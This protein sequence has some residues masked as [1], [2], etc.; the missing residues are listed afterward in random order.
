M[1]EISSTVD[2]MPVVPLQRG[3]QHRVCSCGA[4]FQCHRAVVFP[5]LE[6]ENSPH[7][8][9]LCSGHLQKAFIESHEI[10]V[11]AHQ[12]FSVALLLLYCHVMRS[13]RN[14][15]LPRVY[16]QCEHI[17]S[18]AVVIAPVVMKYIVAAQMRHDRMTP[19][20]SR[21]FTGHTTAERCATQHRTTTASIWTTFYALLASS[22]P[23][24][25]KNDQRLALLLIWITHDLWRPRSSHVSNNNNITCTRLPSLCSPVS[26]QMM[27]LAIPS[28][29]KSTCNDRRASPLTVT[30]TIRRSKNPLSTNAY[31][32]RARRSRR[33]CRTVEARWRPL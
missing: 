22:V 13:S 17:W 10:V 26:Q 19:G 4:Q 12:C 2:V 5:S 29:V 21:S 30:L 8:N 16:V 18:S 1:C 24:S 15:T 28:R 14:Y 31:G 33:W 6:R 32:S 9:D 25:R 20:Q 7:L 11:R 3:C 27:I 23:R